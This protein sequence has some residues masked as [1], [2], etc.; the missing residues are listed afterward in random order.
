MVYN[1][2]DYI[3]KLDDRITKGANH[4]I[5]CDPTSGKDKRL[6]KLITDIMTKEDTGEIVDDSSLNP[7]DTTG[8]LILSREDLWK[9][10]CSDSFPPFLDGLGK[11]HKDGVPLHEIS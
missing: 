11:I 5:K 6:N 1:Q 2:P 10:K 4:K 9:Y 7:E 8:V 3:T